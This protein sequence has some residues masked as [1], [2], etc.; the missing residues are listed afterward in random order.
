MRSITVGLLFFWVFAFGGDTLFAGEDPT[1]WERDIRVLEA[2]DKQGKKPKNPVVFVGSSSIRLWDT[3][4]KDM[5]PLPVLNKG[6][7][8]AKLG[9]V[10]Y[11]ADRLVAP[12]QPTAVVVFAGTNDITPRHSKSPEAV[13]SLYKELVGVIR[14]N[15]PSLPIYFIAITPSQ[16][17]WS[18]WPIAQE[19]NR[20]IAAYAAKHENLYVVDTAKGLL[21]K[22]GQ[23]RS[24]LYRADRLHLN[25]GGYAIWTRLIKPHL[26]PL[27]RH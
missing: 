25:A 3:L 14:K 7:G 21:G 24:E 8:G 4:E 16:Q 1:I 5:A 10:I 6:F 20:L 18:V 27:V 11:Y 17:R 9:D 2:R 26:L 19:A 13:L 22:N 23:P 15:Q 12:H